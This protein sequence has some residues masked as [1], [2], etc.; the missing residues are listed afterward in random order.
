MVKGKRTSYSFYL[1]FFTFSKSKQ[2]PYLNLVVSPV[3]SEIWASGSI[4]GKKMCSIGAFVQML[5]L[6]QTYVAET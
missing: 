1:C 5:R 4:K 6:I 3:I 2:I